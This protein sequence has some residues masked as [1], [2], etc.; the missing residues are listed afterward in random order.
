MVNVNVNIQHSL[1]VPDG[2][3]FFYMKKKI[4]THRAARTDIQ[5]QMASGQL[6]ILN[7]DTPTAKILKDVGKS[8]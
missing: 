8:V 6:L 1:V 7:P 3:Q 5:S 4:Y 2:S